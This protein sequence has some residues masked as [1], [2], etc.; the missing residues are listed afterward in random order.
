M[1]AIIWTII[2]VLVIGLG[3]WWFNNEP[4]TDDLTSQVPAGQV[5]ESLNGNGTE[6][7][8][9]ASNANG[10]TELGQFQDKG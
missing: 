1:K 2:L 8:S 5:D 10:G 6:D 4:D 3:V 7:G 9:D